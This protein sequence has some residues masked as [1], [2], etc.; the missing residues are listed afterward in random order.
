MQSDTAAPTVFQDGNNGQISIWSPGLV[1]TVEKI[2]FGTPNYA[3]AG[4]NAGIGAKFTGGGTYLLFGTSSTYTGI[5]NTAL[6]ITPSSNLE[7]PDSADKLYASFAKSVDDG[8]LI[9]V[10]NDNDYANRNL[11]ITDYANIAKDHDHDTLSANPTLF[12]HSATNPDVANNEWLSLSHNTTSAE[13]TSGK[14]FFVVNP[15]ITII[16]YGRI[17]MGGS[18]GG[19]VLYYD[20]TMLQQPLFLG[21]SH[22]NFVLA[23]LTTGLGKNYDHALQANPTLFIHSV[24]D[25]DVNNTQWL[26]FAHDQTNGVIQAG[27]G[28]VA[29]QGNAAVGYNADPG[30]MFLGRQGAGEPN[31]TIGAYYDASVSPSCFFAS[32]IYYNGV[33]FLTQDA[34]KNMSMWLVQNGNQ[35]W[36]TGGAGGVAPGT[37]KMSLSL[38]GGFSLGNA[39]ALTDAGAGNLLMTGSIT[40]NAAGNITANSGDIVINPSTD[41]TE[42]CGVGLKTK[43]YNA[44]LN[45]GAT[46]SLPAGTGWGTFMIGDNQ[47]YARVRWTSA[48][49]P[50]VDE[51]TA[52]VATSDLAGNLCFIDG[53]ATITIKNNLG[54]NLTLRY[55]IHYS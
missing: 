1:N 30:Y 51:S 40:F 49:V 20:P 54:S 12:V 13:L 39:V 35:Y 28:L 8:F 17:T 31:G 14:G 50:T 16:D 36:Y 6:R 32:N 19:S 46:V 18:S 11:I 23:D 21:S 55:V 24:T 45:N 48:A 43:E 25:P 37:L 44:T 42:V 7:F 38:A 33:S 52:N 47:E 3:G 4:G 53:G 34:T 27:T 26:S 2:T 29:I 15:G 41:I 22:R 9:G 5:S 10:G